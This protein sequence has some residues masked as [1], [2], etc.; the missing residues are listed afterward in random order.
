M[1]AL[2]L[3][4]H[5]Y[6]RKALLNVKYISAKSPTLKER[7]HGNKYAKKLC[8]SQAQLLRLKV[9]DFISTSS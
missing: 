3:T 6:N 4:A 9:T 7:H 1:D 5:R 2:I 8:S